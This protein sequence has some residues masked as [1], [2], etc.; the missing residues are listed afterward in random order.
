MIDEELNNDLIEEDDEEDFLI[1]Y[2]KKRRSGRYKYGSGE[3]PYQHEPWFKWESEVDKYLDQGMSRT[4]V[5]KAMGMSTNE[6]RQRTATMRAQRDAQ[7]SAAVWEYKQQGRSLPEISKRMGLNRGTVERLLDIHNNVKAQKFNNTA[8]LL[9][10][11]VKEKQFIDVS[12]GTEVYLG[13][14]EIGRA[15]V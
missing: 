6:F 8:N 13:I 5:A 1:H 3:I 2:G 7:L 15:H 4:E 11:A 12:G 9:K 10:D 14:K